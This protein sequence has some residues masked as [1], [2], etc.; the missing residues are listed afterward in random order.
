MKDFER[1]LAEALRGF[2]TI[3]SLWVAVPPGATTGSTRTDDAKCALTVEQRKVLAILA[4]YDRDGGWTLPRDPK[5]GWQEGEVPEGRWEVTVESVWGPEI[6]QERHREVRIAEMFEGDWLNT[7]PSCETV[8]AY[9]AL[10]APWTG[11]K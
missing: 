10:P 3:V 8:L 2:I 7:R 4:A 6:Q 1:E 9:R 11:G 5:K